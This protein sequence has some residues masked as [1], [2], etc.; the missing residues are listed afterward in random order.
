MINSL[1]GKHVFESKER[2]GLL[3]CIYTALSGHLTGVARTGVLVRLGDKGFRYIEK[4]D[5]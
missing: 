2:R 1:S 5:R 3:V 4:V